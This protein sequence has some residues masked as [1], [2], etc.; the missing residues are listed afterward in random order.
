MPS[1][2]REG[3]RRLGIVVGVFGAV[4][5]AIGGYFL[6]MDAHASAASGLLGEPVLVDYG[7]AASLPILGFIVFWGAVRVLVWI[8]VGFLEQPTARGQGQTAGR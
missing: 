6:A 8:C 5:G 4:A 2:F 7:V 3:M 1:N